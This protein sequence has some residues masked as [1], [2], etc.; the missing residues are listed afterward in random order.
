MQRAFLFDLNRCTGC[1][2]CTLAC[3]VENALDPGMRWRQVITFNEP[4]FP[5]VPLFS[6]SLACNHCLDAP[7]KEKCPALAYTKDERTG[8]VLIDP[9]LCMGCKYCPWVC[10]YDAPQFNTSSGVM[11]KCTFCSHRLMDGLEPACTAACPTAAL[12]FGDYSKDEGPQPTDIPGF[13]RNNIQPA[14]HIR[15]L[16]RGTRPPEMHAF[17]EHEEPISPPGNSL[18][19]RTSLSGEW[20]LLVFTLT[21]AVLVALFH[22]WVLGAFSLDATSF[23]LAGLTAM[24]LSTGHLG[25]KLRFYRAI[26]NWKRSWVS[27][28]ILLFSAFFVG[29]TY[30]MTL[31]PF[32]PVVGRLVAAIGFAALFA[33]DKVYQLDTNLA[34]S[35]LHS[36]SVLLTGI[37]L[38]GVFT[39]HPY[40]LF[41]LGL[42]KFILYVSRWAA[43]IGRATLTRHSLSTARILFGFVIPASLWTFTGTQHYSLIVAGILIGEIVDRIE[44]YMDLD[45]TLPAAKAERDLDEMIARKRPVLAGMTS[46]DLSG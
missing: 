16:R 39:M 1:H 11:E 32:E 13:W 36:A 42:A 44:H 19:Y 17:H 2:A 31:V 30:V 46:Q 6:L 41:P 35:R 10:P 23:A 12:R 21:A 9:Q 7:C 29:A 45:F 25:K 40:F 4:R 22:S 20:P 15:P 33:M 43:G 8:A 18:P 28:E 5:A 27:R 24:G 26:L 37:Y 14:I 3:K 38:V 34:R